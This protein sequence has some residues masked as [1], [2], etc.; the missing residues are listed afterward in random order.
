MNEDYTGAI[1]DFNSSLEINPSCSEAYCNRGLAKYHLEDFIGAIADCSKAIA[2]NLHYADAYYVRGNAKFKRGN[3]MSA[4][5]DYNKV[6][7]LKPKY[8][9]AYFNRGL[10]LISIK[11]KDRGC[12]DFSKAGELGNTS[13]YELIKEYCN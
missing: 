13:A 9:E 11:A 1:I 10:A 8:A 6:I 7:A 4:I 3:A 2:I 5:V 12:A